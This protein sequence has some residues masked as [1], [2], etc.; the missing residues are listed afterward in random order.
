MTTQSWAFAA[1]HSSDAGF[2]AW[3]SDF[4]AKLALVGLVQ[5]ADTGQINWGTV[6]RPGT[7]TD[8]GYEIWRFNDTQQG[9]API[10]IRFGY[11]TG[12]SATRGRIR[13][14]VGTGTNGAG[15]ITGTATTGTIEAG[16]SANIT[17]DGTSRTCYMCHVDGCFWYARG[18]TST[19][20]MS[21]FF[22]CRTAD[23]SG[24]A[25]ANGAYT[26]TSEAVSSGQHRTQSLRF[27]AT[28]AAYT[29]ETSSGRAAQA[30][31]RETSTLVGGVPQVIPVIGWSPQ[32]YPVF[33]LGVVLLSEIPDLSTF[34]WTP[35]GATSHT[36]IVLNQRLGL[37]WNANNTALYGLALI[38]E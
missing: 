24:A 23:S 33:G 12:T 34:T 27:A 17:D 20:D 1:D 2:R 38:W 15:T 37:H 18:T 16:P 29:A 11:G 10:Y 32:M 25:D 8:A 21:H 19:A 6:T 28:A 7:N 14:T 4:A 9:T 13:I 31:G 36:Y 22:I 5:T 35:F 30:I 26:L 3:G